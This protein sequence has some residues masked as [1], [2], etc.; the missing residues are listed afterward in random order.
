MQKAA[1]AIYAPTSHL[2]DKIFCIAQSNALGVCAETSE[3]MQQNL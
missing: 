1:L 3:Q 2:Y